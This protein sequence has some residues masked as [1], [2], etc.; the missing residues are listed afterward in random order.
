MGS[1]VT[2][3]S[4]WR[5]WRASREARGAFDPDA[6][7]D[8]DADESF[9][10][11]HAPETAYYHSAWTGEKGIVMKRVASITLR[12][13]AIGAIFILAAGC[14]TRTIYLGGRRAFP[15]KP[16]FTIT[17]REYTEAELAAAGIRTDGVYVHWGLRP[18]ELRIDLENTYR[19]KGWKTGNPF[20]RFWANG[21]VMMRLPNV[22]HLAA[23]DVDSFDKAI[24]GYYQIVTNN[25]GSSLFSV[26]E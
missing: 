17:P 1:A 4:T 19:E 22:D 10:C 26:A 15:A 11:C 16:Q 13:M 3:T 5:T 12:R 9:G 14:V 24:L 21:R 6:D 8:T 2:T 23:E 20:R 25:V 18:E 7:T